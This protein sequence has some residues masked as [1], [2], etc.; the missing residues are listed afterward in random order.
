MP[1]EGVTV[2]IAN[3]RASVCGGLLT[4][5]LAVPLGAAV[6]PAA[7]AVAHDGEPFEVLVFSKTAGFR[8]GS[9]P[10][11]IAAIQ[12]LG[13]E[14]NFG[15]D[16]TEDA[17]QFTDANLSQYDAVVWLNTTGDVLDAAQQGAFERYI[18]AGG[19]YAG[20]HS[21]SDTEYGWA[22][23]GELV[24][25]YFNNHPANQTASIKV[26]DPAHPST[27]HLG[28]RWE[29]FDEWYNFQTNPRGDVHVLAS[30]DES[31]YAP[32]SG[33]MGAEHPVAWCQDYDGGRA[34]YTALGHTNEAYGEPAFR[35]HL[36]GG[37]ETAAGV[38][39]A[40]C[41]ASLTSSFEKV[42]LDEST[43]NPMKL[44]VAS[45]GRV[46][47]ID[48][49]GAVRIIRPDGSTATAGTI[50]VYTG[51]EFG[52]LGLALDPDFTSNGWV[53][54]YYSPAGGQAIDRLSRFTMNGDSLDVGS[55]VTLLQVGTQRQECCHA[56]GALA[57]D[58]DGNLYLA[59]GDNTNPFASDGY[60]P[61]DERP[62]RAFWD[63]QRTAAN[64]N[65]LNGKVLRIHPEDSGTYTV[66]AGNLFA[67]G[68][69]N[70][71]PEIFAMGFRNPFTIG[72]DPQ[73]NTLLV[74]D[75]GPDAGS[76]NPGRG[77]DG[78]VEWNI[79]DEPGF[80]GWPYCIGANTPYVD[81]NFASGQSGQPFNCASPVNNSP[82]N[83]GVSQLPPAIGAELWMG[84]S[85]TG[86]PEV[87]NSGAP[88]ASGV[89]R[90]GSGAD[91]GRR[92]PAYWDGRALLGD[93]NNGRLFSIQPDDPVS[94]VSDVSR[95]FPEMSFIRIHDLKWGPDGALYVIDWGTGF[96]GNNTD[97]GIYRIDYLRGGG[98]RDPVAQLTTDRTSGPVPLSVQFSAAGSSD[99][100]GMP[101]SYAWDFDGN[102]TT[103]AT[104]PQVSRTYTQAGTYLAALTVTT[105]DDRFAV[106][107]VEIV[108]GNTAPTITIQAPVNGGLFDFGDEIRYEVTVTDAEDGQVDCADVV[109]QP[110][111]GHDEHAHGYEQYF[112]CEG[113][114]PLPGD[115]GHI[116]A[117]IFG[118]VT[119]T[120]TDQGG[121]NGAAPLTSQ[122][123][124]VLH[125][126]EKEAEYFADHG[127]IPGG[128]GTDDPGVAVES[129]TDTGGG[130]NI[131]W[132]TDG[133]W[134]GFRPMNLTGIDAVQLRV[135]SQ[136]VGG[137]IEVRAN[138]P[139]GPLVGSVAVGA[140]GG[141]QNWTTVTAQLANIPAGGG[142]ALYF[143]TRRPSGSTS[144][145]FLI[146][147]NWV[148]FQ[149]AGI[150][151][152]GGG[153]GD[154]GELLS[155]DSGKCLEVAGMSTEPG[156]QAQIWDCTGGSNQDWTYTAA[157][158]LSVYSGGTRRCLDAEGGGTSAGTS[159]IIWTC[160]GGTN[161]QWQRNANGT[162]TGVQSGLC[163]DVN[164]GGTAN[165]T[166]VIMWNCH[167]GTNQQWTLG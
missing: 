75:Y 4:A 50:G 9:I 159:V 116:G 16:A 46:F 132:I 76:S 139:Q 145:S 25:A 149:G 40:D 129:T 42:A 5:V 103:D 98:S 71:R 29:W 63:A 28:S 61:I 84:K 13:A 148:E 33:A 141:W 166:A 74:A 72:V 30:V 2:T 95:I 87:G 122:E 123:V 60:T 160:H 83:T 14:H 21:A 3:L 15:V 31:S 79:V 48:R 82:N 115:V 52:L 108:A 111:L 65:V 11:G 90:F 62:G 88:T 39:D 58:S 43:S 136:T 23:Y 154:S 150:G 124:V 85:S 119:V 53:Y 114:F 137:T 6:V 155:A 89:Y 127:R 153:G 96:G 10:A 68:T 102:G 34:W 86:V 37:I 131:G 12:Q 97:S 109:T 64:S 130:Q 118:V 101:L 7:P 55:E 18:R 164:G 120:Y 134:F 35:D 110:A 47:Y 117:D 142:S 1:P 54:L 151:E 158:E 107:D 144:T 143:V 157:G 38:V 135:A 113:S 112:G 126:K 70:T 161:Q 59:T 92:W 45:D 66:P 167:G 17:S 56:G 32:G 81:Y 152:G 146:N 80:Y 19:G 22:W 94:G 147:V 104:G 20:V 163:I 69:P 77:P 27:A 44:D 49:G 128:A 125:T 162:I 73:T 8:H 41:G 26:E 67:P 133:D 51:Q 36:A 165:G 78:R 93:W 156:S 140:T 105:P 106:A 100:E 57:F 91:P 121:A 24:G 99:P 138:D